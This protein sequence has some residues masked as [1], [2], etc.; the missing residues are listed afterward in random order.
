MQLTDKQWQALQAVSEPG[1]SHGR[2]FWAQ[3]RARWQGPRRTLGSLEWH[4]LVS[5]SS[6]GWEIT[7]AGRDQLAARR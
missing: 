6:E 4:G 2:L 5:Y 1:S 7:E 3:A